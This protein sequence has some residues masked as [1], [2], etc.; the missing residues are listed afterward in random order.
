MWLI[1]LSLNRNISTRGKKMNISGRI[2]PCSNSYCSIFGCYCINFSVYSYCSRFTCCQIES[3]TVFIFNICIINIVIY[4]SCYC[5]RSGTAINL[6]ITTRSINNIKGIITT[7]TKKI[8]IAFYIIDIKYIITIPTF[9]AI[10]EISTL[11]Y[12]QNIV[13]VPSIHPCFHFIKIQL[14][15][16]CFSIS[17]RKLVIYCNS[18]ITALTVKIIPLISG[19]LINCII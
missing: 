17:C 14:I 16:S 6:Q 4:F 8:K 15:I 10:W 13:A 7:F 12:V 19:N 5:I 2:N 1:L 18:I 11:I 9:G 3:F